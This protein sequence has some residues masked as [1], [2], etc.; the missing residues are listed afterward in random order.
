MPA[1]PA[2]QNKSSATGLLVPPRLRRPRSRRECSRQREPKAVCIGSTRLRFGFRLAGWQLAAALAGRQA[3][4]QPP[5]PP[6]GL[7]DRLVIPA[8]TP[9]TV[10]AL[11]AGGHVNRLG[12]K[13]RLTWTAAGPEGD[14]LRPR[15]ATVGAGCVRGWSARR[16]E[17][18]QRGQDAPPHDYPASG[19]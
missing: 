15:I 2:L 14:Y 4:G 7:A 1:P 5:A 17:Q 11:D 9:G 3:P 10:P 12:F 16:P 13:L 6:P 18:Q 8:G 19:S